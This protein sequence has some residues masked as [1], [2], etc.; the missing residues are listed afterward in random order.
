MW[1]GIALHSPSEAAPGQC[2]DK[3]L[4]TKN[5]AYMRAS[6]QVFWIVFSQSECR[7]CGTTNGAVTAGWCT[8]TIAGLGTCT[9]TIDQNVSIFSYRSGEHVCD[10]IPVGDCYVEAKNPVMFIGMTTSLKY[11]CVL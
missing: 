10:S 7:I 6:G 2:Y 3:C 8:E 1:I 9:I 4:E 5:I 11:I